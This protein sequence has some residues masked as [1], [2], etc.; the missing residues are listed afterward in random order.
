MAKQEKLQLRES[1]SELLDRMLSDELLRQEIRN[2]VDRKPQSAWTRTS[3]HPLVITI[4]GFLL[5]GV[6]ASLLTKEIEDARFRNN[7]LIE[8]AKAKKLAGVNAVN[9]L[10]ALIYERRVRAEL[11]A[12]SLRRGAELAEVRARKQAY[13]DAYTRWNINVQRTNL[14]IREMVGAKE[15]SKI[16]AHIQYGLTPHLRTADAFLT[17]GYDAVVS[18]DQNWAYDSKMLKPAL[19]SMLD[20]G[21]AITQYLWVT[22]NF[23]GD[24]G[25]EWEDAL[26][27][28]NAELSSTC[29]IGQS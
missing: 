26:T 14:T 18:G 27:S 1:Q 11:L 15:Y 16:E 28:A 3:R 12:S 9:E 24:G 13:D 8:N 7:L 19:A 21:Y 29:P 5:T 25:N 20:C 23:Y 22:T 4:V 17:K 6:V 2:I 10:A